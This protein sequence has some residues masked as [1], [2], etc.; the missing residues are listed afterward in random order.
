M[1]G[2]TVRFVGIGTCT[3]RASQPGDAN[4]QAAPLVQQSFSVGLVLQTISFTSTPPAG[5]VVGVTTYTVA[6]TATSGLPVVFSADPSSARSA[7]S[8]GRR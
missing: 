3:I 1:I 6:A 5:A 2:T 7:R 4:Y 8:R